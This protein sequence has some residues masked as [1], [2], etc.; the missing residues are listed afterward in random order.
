MKTINILI[1]NDKLYTKTKGKIKIYECNSLIDGTNIID[2]NKF[3]KKIENIVISSSKYYEIFKPNICF[4]LPYNCKQNE[5]LSKVFNEQIINKVNVIELK[6]LFNNYLTRQYIIIVNNAKSIDVLFN[7]KCY[8]F[9]KELDI[10]KILNDYLNIS[11]NLSDDNKIYVIKYNKYYYIS[12][13][14]EFCLKKTN[15]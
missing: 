10:N 2:I 12:D 8:S 7:K 14:D 15:L 4:F 1:F 13:S 11:I 6:E 5:Y 3:I 9:S